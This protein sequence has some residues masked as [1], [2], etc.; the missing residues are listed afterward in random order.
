MTKQVDVILYPMEEFNTPDGTLFPFYRDWDP[1][2]N[3]HVPK[4]VY[5]SVM[6]PLCEKD[7]ILHNKRTSYITSINGDV[8]ITYRSSEQKEETIWL[9]SSGQSQIALIKPGIP[10]KVKN[11]SSESATVINAC[12]PAWHPDDPD[13]IK[14][15]TWDDYDN[16][17]NI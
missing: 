2:H 6:K 12:S 5:V 11:L 16:Y 13:T 14:F 7:I 4:M 3:G 8:I 9:R 15:K 1:W 17:R 10:I